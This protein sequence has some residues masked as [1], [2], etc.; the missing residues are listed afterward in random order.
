MRYIPEEMSARL[1]SGVT[2]LAHVWRFVRRDGAQYAFTDHDRPLAF[3]ALIAEP[4]A[5]LTSGVIEKALGLG[6]DTASVSGALSSAAISEDDL[7][8]GLW[9][10]ARVDIFRVDWRDATLRVHLFAGRVGEVRRGASA[11]EAELRGLQAV[12]NKPVG[13]VFSR[14][15]DAD[16]GDG[17]CGK[18][19]SGDAFTGAGIVSELISNTIFRATGLSAYAENW[20]A[21]G[22]IVWGAGGGGEVSVHRLEGETAYIELLDPAG[23][24]LALG[25]AFTIIAG[26]DKRFE[27]CRA[28]FANT[29][30]FRGFPH[31]PGNDSLQ[32]GPQAGALLDGGSRHA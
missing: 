19:V 9:D 18:D 5:G 1:A 25:A 3:D 22:R 32:S 10:G 8:R 12:L 6:V 26:C 23:P 30:N 7:A 20:F 28:K 16:L 21:R 11:F 24:V 29:L 2:M 31:M 13:R 27:T 15:C 14:F 17:R 4:M